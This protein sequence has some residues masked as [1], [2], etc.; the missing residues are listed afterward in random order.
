MRA[1]GQR[2]GRVRGWLVA[3][4]VVALLFFQLPPLAPLAGAVREALLPAAGV[5]ARLGRAV[6]GRFTA[7][8]TLEDVQQEN[9]RL[10]AETARVGGE[11]TRLAELE[12][13]NAFL[14]AALGFQQQYPQLSFLPAEVLSFEPTNLAHALTI[15]RG[16]EDGLRPGT[17]VVTP[18]GVVGQVTATTARTAT[19]LLLTDQRSAVDARAQQSEARGVVAGLGRSD[20]LLMRYVRQEEFLYLGERV[21]T[22]GLGGLFPPGLP[23]GRVGYVQRRD[24]DAFQE[25]YVEP[26]TDFNRLAQVLVLR[27][28]ASRPSGAP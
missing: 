2:R 23:V 20:L 12:R 4:L 3:V 28:P 18:E 10:R 26:A 14:L 1:R 25:A 7:W 22:S 17:A 24:V 8:R 15:D 27:P 21:V 11:N 6:E 19:V 13:Q 9:A 5:L 16:E